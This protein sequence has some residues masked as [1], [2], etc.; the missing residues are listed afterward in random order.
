MGVMDKIDKLMGN[1]PTQLAFVMQALAVLMWV[2]ATVT[3]GLYASYH[4]ERLEVCVRDTANV[5]NELRASIVE[6]NKALTDDFGKHGIFTNVAIALAVLNGLAVL[7][8]LSMFLATMKHPHSSSPFKRLAMFC[9]TLVLPSTAALAGTLTASRVSRSITLTTETCKASMN[10]SVV[11]IGILALASTL[12]FASSAIITGGELIQGSL[13]KEKHTNR[14]GVHFPMLQFSMTLF[15]SICFA[16]VIAFTKTTST[17]LL[18]SQQSQINTF[19]AD[20]DDLVIPI[21]STVMSIFV[22]LAIPSNVV[23]FNYQKGVVNR[24]ITRP[25]V[26][27]LVTSTVVCA[28]LGGILIGFFFANTTSRKQDVTNARHSGIIQ[29]ASSIT[30]TGVVAA[31]LVYIYVFVIGMKEPHNHDDDASAIP[32]VNRTQKSTQNTTDGRTTPLNDPFQFSI[33]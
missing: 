21:A 9:L 11:V 8:S 14:T 16:I 32:L 23:A 33:E 22:L 24:K 4:K 5:P 2:G 12:A 25:L 13:F 28:F 6:N 20:I 10:E 7:L 30:I 31:G 1:G 26:P 17:S 18:A 27:L 3:S 29:W 19:K 15:I